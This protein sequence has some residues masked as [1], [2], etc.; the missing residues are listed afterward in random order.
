MIFHQR[1]G[2]L[3]G[4]SIRLRWRYPKVFF[5][6]HIKIGVIMITAFCCCLN[7]RGGMQYLFVGKDQAFLLNILVNGKVHVVLKTRDRWDADTCS[8]SDRLQRER[9]SA[10]F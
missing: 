7:G 1:P 6:L 9:S 3:Q 2:L 8:R 10:I 5:V 4:V